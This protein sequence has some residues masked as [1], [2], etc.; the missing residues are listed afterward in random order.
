MASLFVSDRAKP[1]DNKINLETREDFKGLG[2]DLASLQNTDKIIDL[3][4]VLVFERLGN[5]NL[6]VTTLAHLAGESFLA[7]TGA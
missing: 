4:P 1:L 5:I 2:C 6:S 3:H 7:V